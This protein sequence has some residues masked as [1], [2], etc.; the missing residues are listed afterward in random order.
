VD[1]DDVESLVAERLMLWEDIPD[2]YKAETCK[3][4]NEKS[5]FENGK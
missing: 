1:V 3:E 2:L 5:V 4:Q